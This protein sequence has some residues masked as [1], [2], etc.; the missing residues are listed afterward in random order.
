MT[1]F[2]AAIAAIVL[3]LMAA[4]P[5]AA[6][7]P[8]DLEL[9]LAI[10]VSGSI[11]QE[12]A[13]LQREGYLSALTHPQVIAAIKT[14]YIGRIAITYF[15]WAGE[16]YQR[17]VADWMVVSDETS[18][19]ALADAIARQPVTTELWTS[20]TG[21][22]RYA[23][24]RFAAS[25]Y[26]GKRRILDISGDG[27]NNRGGSVIQARDEAVLAGVTINGLPIINERPSRWGLPPSPNLDLYYQECVI[28]G[29][30]AFLIVAD[31]FK[32]FAIAIR[33]KLILEIAGVAPERPLLWLAQ[34]RERPYG[35]W[36][37][38]CDEGERQL[39]QFRDR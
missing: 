11:D 13:A 7:E 10:D 29:R 39:R 28:G 38:P 18:A 32:D 20:I 31:S 37:P 34:G 9:V 33:K 5:L 35:G 26:A 24:A 22:I 21:A 2:G 17:T 6:A 14:G 16:H 12:E 1:R 3:A 25:P 23:M 4:R 30:G 15:E 27:P 8:V 19:K 36:R